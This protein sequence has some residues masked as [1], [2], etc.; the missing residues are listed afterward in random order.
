M[1]LSYLASPNGYHCNQS[2]A[3]CNRPNSTADDLLHILSIYAKIY[4]LSSRR[5]G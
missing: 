4:L 3:T 5:C 1:T 2:G